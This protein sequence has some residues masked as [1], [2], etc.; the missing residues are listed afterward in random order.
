MC[1]TAIIPSH[2]EQSLPAPP[3]SLGRKTW[4]VKNNTVAASVPP[5]FHQLIHS[6]DCSLDKQSL[7]TTQWNRPRWTNCCWR[8]NSC[9]LYWCR[10]LPSWKQAFGKQ[11][12]GKETG[13]GQMTSLGIWVPVQSSALMTK[14]PFDYYYF[15][16]SVL[17]LCWMEN[18]KNVFMKFLWS[19]YC[20][21]WLEQ[22]TNLFS[23]QFKCFSLH[24]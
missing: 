15:R 3:L 10:W 1:F 4:I 14:S 24:S 5:F 19:F 6:A 17:F 20:L 13:S 16:R 23:P 2:R 8:G 21:S 11:K 12:C 18:E 22:A 9:W 7:T